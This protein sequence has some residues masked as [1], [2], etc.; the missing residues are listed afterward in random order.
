MESMCSSCSAFDFISWNRVKVFISTY[1][2]FSLFSFPLVAF[3]LFFRFVFLKQVGRTRGL[4]CLQRMLEIFKRGEEVVSYRLLAK[5]PFIIWL[6]PS[7]GNK[8]QIASCDWPPERAKWS[9]LARSGL[10]T[11]SRKKIFPKAI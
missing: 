5:F 3:V 7:P 11:V 4:V 2:R 6:A 8:N 1:Q 9:D 10:P